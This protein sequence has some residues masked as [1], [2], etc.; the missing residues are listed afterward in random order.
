MNTLPIAYCLNVNYTNLDM[1]LENHFNCGFP[2]R[3]IIQISE[4][5]S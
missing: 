1:L 5:L 2:Y 4:S 3:E